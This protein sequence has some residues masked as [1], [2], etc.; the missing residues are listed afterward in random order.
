MSICIWSLR[1]EEKTNPMRSWTLQRHLS[2]EWTKLF[3]WETPLLLV[4]NRPRYQNQG[5]GFEMPISLCWH[6]KFVS[7]SFL[8]YLVNKTTTLLFVERHRRVKAWELLL[9]L[10]W[11]V[12]AGHRLRQH[13]TQFLDRGARH[14]LAADWICCW[15][16][17]LRGIFCPWR[18]GDWA[19]WR[20]LIVRRSHR[21][22]RCYISY[23]IV[24]WESIKRNFLRGIQWW[25]QRVLKM[26]GT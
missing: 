10:S 8:H 12:V 25:H 14:C 4:P 22:K 19:W 18:W 15:E 3:Q 2:L 9:W 20:G 6:K 13:W 1:K 24:L 23:I 17:D 7:Y 5:R 16:H 26:T 21:C 11:G